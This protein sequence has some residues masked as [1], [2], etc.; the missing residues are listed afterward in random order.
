[1]NGRKIFKDI[2][3]AGFDCALFLDEN[4]QYYLS[5]FYTTDGAVIVVKDETADTQNCSH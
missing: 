3:D 5:D 2:T 1:M 4:S